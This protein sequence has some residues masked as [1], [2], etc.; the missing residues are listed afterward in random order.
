MLNVISITPDI[1][2]L[3]LGFILNKSDITAVETIES[4]II[5]ISHSINSTIFF[6]LRLM[7]IFVFFTGSFFL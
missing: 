3:M 5:M 7:P 1:I 6:L 4:I 2:A